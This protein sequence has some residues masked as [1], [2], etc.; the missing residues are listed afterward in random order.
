MLDS[1]TTLN[2][3]KASR[4]IIIKSYV[5]IAKEGETLRVLLQTSTSD[6]Q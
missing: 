4:K 5:L 2:T 6:H 1:K 3:V